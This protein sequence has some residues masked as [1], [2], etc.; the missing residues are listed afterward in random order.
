VGE[1]L[2]DGDVGAEGLPDAGEL[3]ADHAAAEDDHAA[4]DVVEVER[5][6]GGHDPTADLQARQALGVRAGREDDVAAGVALAVDLDGVGRD[7]AAGSFDERHVAALHQALQTLVEAADHAIAVRVDLG[8]VDAI[9]RRAHAEGVALLRRVSDLRR[10]QEG[11]GGD[12]AA[13]Q[14][15]PAELVLVDE[16]DGHAELRRAQRTGVAAASTTEDHEVCV[17]HCGLLLSWTVGLVVD[18]GHILPPLRPD[19]TGPL[20]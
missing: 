5:L 1:C 2:D 20:R 13:M 19:G 18:C 10:V 9:E 4:R 15:G 14:A 3:H 6:V 7:Q 11:L 16:H 17:G 8:H 12:A